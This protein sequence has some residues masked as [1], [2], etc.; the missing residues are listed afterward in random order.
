MDHVRIE[1]TGTGEAVP[2]NVV[3]GGAGDGS[4][5]D[6]VTSSIKA[7]VLDFTNSNPLAV[8]LTDTNGDYAAAGGG[9]QYADAAARGTATGTLA[10]GDDGTNIQS[11]KVDAAGEL[12]ID[13]LSSALPTGAATAAL[14]TQPGV[15]IGD[16][17]I[18]NAAGAAAVN[19]QDGGNVITVD[20]TIAATQSGAWDVSNVELPAAAAA[21]DNF[22]NPTTTNLMAMGMVWDGVAWDRAAGTSVDG[23]LVNLGTNNDVTVT[24]GTI[25]LA[26]STGT[27]EVVGD[28]ADA[29]AA[30]GNPVSIGLTARTTNRTAVADGNNV[31]AA[32]DDMGRQVVITGQVRDLIGQQHT[33]IA[34][35]AAETTIITAIASTFCDLVQLVI[36]NQTAT[37]VNVTIKDSTAGTTR[38]IIAL[39]ASGGAVIPF[40]RPIP[41]ATVNNNWT[42]TLSSD[43]VTVNI[44]ALYER[45][46]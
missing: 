18:N 19:I 28:V 46:V 24:S 1:N 37:A 39:A 32:A 5:L 2:V 35:S 16:V 41:Q 44:F 9:T 12:Q 33:Q 43:A 42:A 29:V 40:T 4:L 23:S 26:A 14:Q 27:Q 11:I 22:A 30:A 31:R 20:G 10:M 45:N 34:S 21:S 15:D 8:R 36:T 38:M 13:V 3:A 25:T 7:T 17:T 6:G